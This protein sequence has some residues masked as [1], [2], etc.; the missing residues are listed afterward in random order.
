MRKHFIPL[1]QII[2]GIIIS[3][4]LVLFSKV[5]TFS[6]FYDLTSALAFKLNSDS[7]YFFAKSQENFTFLLNLRKIKSERD[8]LQIENLKISSEKVILEEQLDNITQQKLQESFGLNYD[9]K[10]VLVVRV[11]QDQYGEIFINKGAR[12]NVQIGDIL[13][14]EKYA[15]GEV[16]SIS[17]TGAL[18]RLVISPKS[19]IPAISLQTKTKGIIIGDVQKG[20]FLDEVL[21]DSP[22]EKDETIVTSGINSN[23]PAGLI[24]GKVIKINKIASALTKNADLSN[25]VKFNDLREIYLLRRIDE[26]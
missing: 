13:V 14:L 6:V 23:F 26:N 11:N 20:I 25:Q 24:L 8:T 9:L 7:Y 5:G 2:S 18:V 19:K 17:N 12:D 16:I 21:V 15:I 4:L 10:P 22:L 1:G 3:V